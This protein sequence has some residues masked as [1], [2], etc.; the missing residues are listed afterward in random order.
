MNAR[1]SGNA[2]DCEHGFQRLARACLADIRRSHA[3]AIRGDAAGIHRMRIAITRLRAARKFFS[4]V[5]TDGDWRDLAPDIS[6]LNRTLGTARDNDVLIEM[7]ATLPASAVLRDRKRRLVKRSLKDR[8]CV[9]QAL[10]SARYRH[11]VIALG[12]WI[13]DGP[14]RRSDASGG[15]RVTSLNRYAARRFKRWSRRLA[16]EASHKLGEKRLH[17]LRIRAKQFRYMGNALAELGVVHSRKRSDA[18]D[19]ARRLQKTLGDLRDLQ[20]LRQRVGAM[21]GASSARRRRK[22][23]RKAHEAI[24]GFG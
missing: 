23:M 16:D 9:G 10:A 15:L 12:N 7:V 20:R 19:A 22:L 21:H 24:V 6:W 13:D 2:L 1:V 18:I 4:P 17:R 3:A 8:A 5:V 14:W 11:L